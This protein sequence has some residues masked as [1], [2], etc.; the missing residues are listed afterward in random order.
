MVLAA[1]IGEQLAVPL[2]RVGA[3][4]AR[5]AVVAAHVHAEQLAVRALRHARG[6]ADQR[7]GARARP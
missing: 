4:A 3:A 5:E 7:L 1:E 2:D 6:A